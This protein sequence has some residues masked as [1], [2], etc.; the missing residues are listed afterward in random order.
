MSQIPI[1]FK[2]TSPVDT[3]IKEIATPTLKAI[4]AIATSV[5][6]TPVCN[7]INAINSKGPLAAAKNPIYSLCNSEEVPKKSLPKKMLQRLNFSGRSI[8]SGIL[9][10]ELG[11]VLK[12][13]I[14]TLPEITPI[15]CGAIMSTSISLKYEASFNSSNTKTSPF[16]PGCI[17]G[18]LVREIGFNAV[19]GNITE[20][21][22]SPTSFLA[23]TFVSHLG[24]TAMSLSSTLS[25]NKLLKLNPS[26]IVQRT[27]ASF[28]PRLLF[29]GAMHVIGTNTINAANSLLKP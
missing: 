14:K 22:S 9:G 13:E 17:V 16:I 4:S 15:I 20:S 8:P 6:L 26:C 10:Q 29:L 3:S 23:G 18:T 12:E 2:N 21:E 11:K 19:L 28:A 25:Y 5:L 24:N 7:T 27:A 1:N